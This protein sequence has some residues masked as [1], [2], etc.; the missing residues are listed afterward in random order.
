LFL[1]RDELDGAHDGVVYASMTGR[2]FALIGDI[3]YYAQAPIAGFGFRGG[4]ATSR[5]T[6]LP[7]ERSSAT[8]LGGRQYIL[9]RAASN[10]SQDA[11]RA[12]RNPSRVNHRCLGAPGLDSVCTIFDGLRGPAFVSALRL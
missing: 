1:R 9:F 6:S 10:P 2:G 11:R 8:A 5:R 12:S 4:G 3:Y 7:A